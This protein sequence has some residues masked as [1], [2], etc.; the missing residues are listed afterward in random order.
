MQVTCG[1][2]MPVVGRL[3]HTNTTEHGTLARYLHVLY[4]CDICSDI[5]TVQHIDVRMISTDCFSCLHFTQNI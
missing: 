1:Q 3:S 4:L 2:Q 5:Q